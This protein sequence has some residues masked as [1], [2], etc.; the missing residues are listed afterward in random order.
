MQDRLMTNQPIKPASSFGETA[1]SSQHATG[2]GITAGAA[3]SGPAQSTSDNLADAQLTAPAEIQSGFSMG[4]QGESQ[5]GQPA[6][7]D[8]Q[9]AVPSPTTA[10]TF[11]PLANGP[12]APVLEPRLAAVANIADPH[13]RRHVEANVRL[14]TQRQI[15][16]F[17]DAQRQAKAQ[18]KQVIDQGG[19]LSAIPAKLMLQI[20][21]PG[22]QALQDYVMA[23][24]QPATDPV[25]YYGLKNQ[26]L[27]DPVGFQAIDLSNHMAR[28]KKADYAEL[29][30]LQTNL[31]NGQPPADLPLQQIYKANTDRLL[32]Q[33][34]LPT[35]MMVSS[36]PAANDNTPGARQ[37]ALMRQAID[38]HITATEIATGRR[39]TPPEH[40]RIAAEV[41]STF[42]PSVLPQKSIAANPATSDEPQ[43]LASSFG[44]RSLAECIPL[45]A[46]LILP[47]RTY[48]GDPYYQCLA[49]C[50]NEGKSGFREWDKYF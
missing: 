46:E 42:Q 28:L 2:Q 26:A 19:D 44:T 47:T 43:Q 10:P 18:A 32:Q 11:D 33:V 12:Q 34:G 1:P 20:N 4:N 49:A 40:L 6:T 37:A 23:Q 48:N 29:Q 31:R 13:L 39:V 35:Q 25:T 45:C 30:Q 9:R 36:D 41:S 27:D 50:Q 24:G 8:D 17:T 5:A 14:Q 3:D 22:R 16:A 38:Q 15:D 21:T 7:M